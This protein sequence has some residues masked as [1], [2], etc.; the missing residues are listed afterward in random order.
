MNHRLLPAP[1]LAATLALAFASPAMAA[2]HVYASPLATISGG[3]GSGSALVTL[4]DVADTV[5][6]AIS[7]SGLSAPTT[8]SHIHCCTA[9][10]GTGSAAVFVPF[11]AFPS[12]VTAGTYSNTF[13]L[14]ASNFGILLAG[15]DAGESY[16][17]IHTTTLPGGEI[18]GF[19]APVPEPASY[20]LMTLGLLG[21]AAYKRR[22]S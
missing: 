18:Q 20:A 8:A 6:V 12:G 21:L 11:T 5:M 2:T 15:M 4:D 16:V 3:S 17:N 19:L 10:P 9:V 1:A 7:F 14:T 22:K 13:T